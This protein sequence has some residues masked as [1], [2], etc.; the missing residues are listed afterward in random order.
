MSVVGGAFVGHATLSNA[1][2]NSTANDGHVTGTIATGSTGTTGALTTTKT[3]DIIFVAIVTNGAIVSSIADTAVLSWH[4]RVSVD[5]GTGL[6]MEKWFAQSAGTL[7]GDV[8]TVNLASSGN[9]AFAAT[10][11]SGCFFSMPFDPYAI[12]TNI[13][14]TATALTDTIANGD[15]TAICIASFGW[16]GG[17]GASFTQGAGYTTIATINQSTNLGLGIEYQ[18]LNAANTALVVNATLGAAENIVQISDVLMV[19]AG[20]VFLLNAPTNQEATI[21]NIYFNNTV[22]LPG[23]ASLIIARADEQGNSQAWATPISNGSYQNLHIHITQTTS[24]IVL[25]NTSTTDQ[26]LVAWDG[27]RTI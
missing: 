20:N 10:A 23:H 22:G 6:H 3:N 17:S 1:N 19:G 12:S 15:P 14:T 13:Q 21:H 9:A 7:A 25:I 27:L 5:N 8:I 4:Y 11:W 24:G 26:Y 18:V 2:L 16:T